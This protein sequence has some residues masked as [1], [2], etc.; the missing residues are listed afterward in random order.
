MLE[1]KSLTKKLGSFVLSGVSMHIGEGEYFVLLGPTG[2]GKSILIEIIAGLIQPDEGRI[3]WNNKDI[4]FEPPQTRGFAVVYQEYALFPHLTVEQNI[5]YGL[6]AAHVAAEKI[7]DRVKSIAGLLH[8]QDLL[9]RR[10]S[11]LSGGQQQQVALARGLIVEPKLLLLDEP[12]S[13]LD[14]R[15]K[16]RLQKELKRINKELNIS[17]LHVTHDPEEAIALADRICVMLDN[18]IRQI[19][20]PME[21]FREPSDPDVAEF[22]GMKNVL[23]ATKAGKDVYFACGCNI[24]VGAAEESISHIWIKPEEIILSARPF[25][26]SAR[27][28]FKCQIVGVDHHNSLLAVHVLS[29]TMNL[30]ALITYASF[31]DLGL[32]IGTE[33]YLTFKS[34]AVHCLCGQ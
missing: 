27:N 24:Y 28:Q 19:A 16:S 20:T 26:S 5:A 30:T 34:S 15:T 33:M 18:R 23:S 3:L 17:I 4:T 11:T 12:L 10:P 8:I 14:V 9:I 29:G 21:L 1:L 32:E 7:K 6:T 2:V 13:S 31:K 22:L 25:D